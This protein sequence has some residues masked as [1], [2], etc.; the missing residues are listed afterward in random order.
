MTEEARKQRRIT[1]PRIPVWTGIMVAAALML[2]AIPLAILAGAS[3]TDQQ[4][5]ADAAETQTSAIMQAAAPAVLTLDDLCRRTDSLGAE[6]HAHGACDQAERAKTVITQIQQVP[7]PGLSVDQVRQMIATAL[8]SQPKPVTVEQVAAIAA[9]VYARNR[10]ADGKNATPDMVA[11]AV[12]A[13]CSGGACVGKDGKD[14]QDA[15]PI[16]ADEILT[17]VTA[18]CAKNNECAGPAGPSGQQGPA[19]PAGPQG[20]SFVRQYFARDDDGSCL[21]YVESYDPVDQKTTVTSSPA[22]PAACPLNATP[23]LHTKTTG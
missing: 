19:G 20:V 8:A 4:R 12:S 22:G 9:D 21:S 14:G 5:R 23:K 18:Y 6:L 3:G 15:P 17:Q 7:A 16:T 2:A 10:P 13:Y 1:L 11:A